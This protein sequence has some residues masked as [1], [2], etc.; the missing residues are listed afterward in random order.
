[1]LSERFLI[2]YASSHFDYNYLQNKINV[3]E[4]YDITIYNENFIDIAVNKYTNLQSKRLKL[5]IKNKFHVNILLSL[6]I[7][8]SARFRLIGF[9]NRISVVNYELF[10][11]FQNLI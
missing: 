8:K 6:C 2:L 7:R 3:R 5:T 4:W 11:N 10:Y 9:Y 1:M